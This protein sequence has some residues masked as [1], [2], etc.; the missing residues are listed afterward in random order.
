M[1]AIDRAPKEKR[2]KPLRS[3][4]ICPESGTWKEV[5]HAHTVRL[6]KGDRMPT[7]A[8][9]RAVEWQLVEK[10]EGERA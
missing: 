10:T 4:Q 5:G 2:P 8:N 1:N 7:G 6:Q 3:W 9:C